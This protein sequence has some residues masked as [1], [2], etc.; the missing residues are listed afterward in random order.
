MFSFDFNPRDRML[1]VTVDDMVPPECAKAFAA[2]FLGFFQS[3]DPCA[4]PV[5]ILIDLARAPVQQQLSM[6]ESWR[7]ADALDGTCP[8]AV[9]VGSALV[10]MQVERFCQGAPLKTFFESNAA[11]QWLAEAAVS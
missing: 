10:K 8:T 2:E 9:V 11:R 7:I 6:S 5:G 1:V 3:P 4:R